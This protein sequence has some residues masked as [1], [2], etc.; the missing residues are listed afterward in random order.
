MRGLLVVAV[1]PIS[2]ACCTKPAVQPAPARAVSVPAAP[3]SKAPIIALDGEKRGAGEFGDT[4]A[5]LL[6][7]KGTR[8]VLTR[9]GRSVR[10][11]RFRGAAFYV[12]LTGNMHFT[13]S[14]AL[15][16]DRV[17]LV[18]W[19]LDVERQLNGNPAI[20]MTGTCFPRETALVL[21]TG[22]RAR[23]V[24]LG[25]QGSGMDFRIMNGSRTVYGKGSKIGPNVLVI[26]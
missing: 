13:S 15:M 24:R 2:I 18:P 16:Y 12:Q 5:R 9:R 10:S 4:S 1:L 3:V 17:V 8:A 19:R 26:I 7:E 21:V 20:P 23:V 25:R 22:S 6:A 14:T 11:V